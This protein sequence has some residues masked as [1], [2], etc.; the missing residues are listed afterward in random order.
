MLF[1]LI[2]A[3]CLTGDTIP[4]PRPP[5]PPPNCDSGCDSLCRVQH[6]AVGEPTSTMLS[7]PFFGEEAIE[8][9]IYSCV[10]EPIASPLFHGKVSAGSHDVPEGITIPAHL[11]PGM[12][13]GPNGTLLYLGE[14]LVDVSTSSPTITGTNCACCRTEGTS[15]PLYRTLTI[16]QL[17]EKECFSSAFGCLPLTEQSCGSVQYV[18]TFTITYL[19]VHNADTGL[20]GVPEPPPI[21]SNCNTC[22]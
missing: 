4:A 18:A 2:A 20:V 1:A 15:G 13:L 11:L 6:T 5:L 19:A 12:T 8:Y 21:E 22:E 9:S 7:E 10:Q 3:L 16:R 17:V 14:E